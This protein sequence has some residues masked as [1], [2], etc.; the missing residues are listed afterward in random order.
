MNLNECK[1]Q[2]GKL[3]NRISVNSLALDS[4][5]KV[6]QTETIDSR[7]MMP[8]YK[9]PHLRRPQIKKS[10]NK[11][12]LTDKNDKDSYID[13]TM[14]NRKIEIK[15][16]CF[17]INICDLHYL[18]DSREGATLNNYHQRS[19][20]VGGF[21]THPIGEVSA[22]DHKHL[23]WERTDAR[24]YDTLPNG[25]FPQ[26]F[27]TTIVYKDFLIVFGGSAQDECLS[28]VWEYE[29]KRQNWHYK[30]TYGDEVEPR[31]NHVACYTG[32]GNM[33][34]H[35]GCNSK[36]EV[37]DSCLSINLLSGKW[38]S[39]DYNCTYPSL[40]GHACAYVPKANSSYCIRETNILNRFEG[41][42]IFGGKNVEQHPLNDLYH[43][44]LKE[45]IVKVNKITP[46]G[47]GPSA[48][49]SHKMV[50]IPKKQ[51]L[52]VL[53]GR[54]D[55]K[56]QECLT[57]SFDDLFIYNYRY[58]LWCSIKW[59]GI[60][61]YG[62]RYNFSTIVKD[63][64]LFIIGGLSDGLLLDQTPIS[65]LLDVEKNT[66]KSLNEVLNCGR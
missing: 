54:N 25:S 8:K 20:Y 7:L 47:I 6:F 27:H 10:Q 43:I 65:L 19:Y 60:S 16:M 51:Y 28:N 42:W 26:G 31:K 13:D 30:R 21:S 3:M 63:N 64:S 17:P 11:G 22:F 46:K 1:D 9:E 2:Y 52:V 34:I 41:V 55:E 38:S 36:N 37:L 24:T 48:R 4:Q 35:G 14:S 23:S 5:P 62:A 56:F 33:F 29:I 39:L 57:N 32:F 61:S 58:N 44:K 18:P 45:S 53:G 12:D 40:A 66:I 15:T 49:Y 59:H 50:S